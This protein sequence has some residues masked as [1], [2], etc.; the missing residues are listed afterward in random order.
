MDGQTDRHT[1]GLTDK[2]Q[3]QDDDDSSDPV[4]F[5]YIKFL[6]LFYSCILIYLTTYRL[7]LIV[8]YTAY[9]C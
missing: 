1:D 3:Q 2:Y 7:V 5:I 8:K 6:G 9:V 4:I